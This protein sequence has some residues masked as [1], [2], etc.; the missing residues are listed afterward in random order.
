MTTKQEWM[1]SYGADCRPRRVLRRPSL[2]KRVL[3]NLDVL[4]IYAGSGSDARDKTAMNDATEW[5]RAM[6]H[7]YAWKHKV[8]K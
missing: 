7:W 4:S 8:I 6:R 3:D 1:T 5:L 2:T